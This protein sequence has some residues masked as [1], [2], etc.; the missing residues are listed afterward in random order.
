MLR[1]GCRKG[2]DSEIA[3]QYCPKSTTLEELF[4]EIDR[5]YNEVFQW[6]QAQNFAMAS[7][8]RDEQTLI[9]NR[10]DAILFASV[11]KQSHMLSDE[12]G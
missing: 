7:I 10:I 2:S 12:I 5:L 3:E 8:C 4:D 1:L 9:R 11:S 6:V